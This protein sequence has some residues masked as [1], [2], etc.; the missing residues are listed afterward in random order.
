MVGERPGHDFDDV[1]CPAH[2]A[3]CSAAAAAGSTGMRATSVLTE[4]EGWAP[5]FTQ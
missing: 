4:S 2:D 1:A 5:T 3:G